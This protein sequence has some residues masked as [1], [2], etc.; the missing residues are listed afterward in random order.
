[1]KAKWILLYVI[2]NDL[3]QIKIFT[4]AVLEHSIQVVTIQSIKCSLC[5]LS[6]VASNQKNNR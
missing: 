3:M 2:S 5:R 6:H 4:A 1:M